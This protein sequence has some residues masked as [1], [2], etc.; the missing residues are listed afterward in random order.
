M[1]LVHLGVIAMVVAGLPARRALLAQDLPPLTPG[2]RLRVTSPAAGLS[3]EY[4]TLVSVSADSL[5]IWRTL[6]R[7]DGGSWRVDSVR[8][9]LPLS[10]VSDL[11]VAV[12]RA[13]L[14]MRGAVLG[15]SI[16]MLG[17]LVIAGVLFRQSCPAYAPCLSSGA[18][19]EPIG[20]G[21]GAAVGAALGAMLL[22][23][24]SE[25]WVAFP[26]GKGRD[27]QVSLVVTPAG[28]LGLGASLA[29]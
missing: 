14:R 6:L 28:R 8:T 2:Q 24:R 13:P 10:A 19:T 12:E 1:K 20:A 15:G 21:V 29:F 7:P 5:V 9:A 18:A 26:L 23:P 11:D 27:P 16:G 25:E 22:Y 17:G 4:G 3:W